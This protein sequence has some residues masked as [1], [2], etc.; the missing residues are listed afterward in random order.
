MSKIYFLIGDRSVQQFFSLLPGLEFFFYYAR[1]TTIFTHRRETY[2]VVA[3]KN[4]F[5]QSKLVSD[6]SNALAAII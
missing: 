2:G 5:T 4:V 6:W 1:R 3:A